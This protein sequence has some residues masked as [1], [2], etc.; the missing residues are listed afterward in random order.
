M[1]S[2]NVKASLN[3]RENADL[4]LARI[5]ETQEKDTCP[6]EA[7]KKYKEHFLSKST[8]PSLFPE[9][10]KNDQLS[11]AAVLGKNSLDDVKRLSNTLKLSKTYI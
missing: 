4:K 10:L 11:T 7:F 2:K 6:V 3:A 5:Y 9:I 1:L 8:Y